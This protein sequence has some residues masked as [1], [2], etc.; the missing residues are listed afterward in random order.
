MRLILTPFKGH[1]NIKS[2]DPANPASVSKLRKT[3][4]SHTQLFLRKIPSEAGVCSIIGGIGIVPGIRG[5]V[6]PLSHHYHLSAPPIAFR[7]AS[8]TAEA[9]TLSSVI[10]LTLYFMK[11]LREYIVRSLGATLTFQVTLNLRYCD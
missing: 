2:I 8:V 6:R 11:L 7:L 3:I 9:L 10:L 1:S 5:R 4:P